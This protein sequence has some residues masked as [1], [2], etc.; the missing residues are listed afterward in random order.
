MLKEKGVRTDRYSYVVQKDGNYLLFDN[1][2]DPYQ[3][4][5]LTLEE[6][7]ENRLS[8]KTELG[9]WLKVSEDTWAKERKFAN[10]INY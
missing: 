10:R 6:I 4:T 9:N 5:S 7:P 8:F 3:Q 1:I 2:K